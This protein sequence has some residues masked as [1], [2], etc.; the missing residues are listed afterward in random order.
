[1]NEPINKMSIT[2]S[3]SF[4][5]AITFMQ[6]AVTM[7][8]KH[9][10]ICPGSRSAPLSYAAIMLAKQEK[11]K[12]YP[13]VDERTAG[14]IAIGLSR[15]GEYKSSGTRE[16]NLGVDKIRLSQPAQ[17][18]LV[19]TTSGSAPAHLFPAILEAQAAGLPLVLVSA[20]RPGYLQQVGASQ[21]T[22]QK[23][24]FGRACVDSFSI[25]ALDA[26]Q[27]YDSNKFSSN[28]NTDSK[29]RQQLSYT[30]QIALRAL[31]CALG[32]GG[33]KPGPV[34]V[35]F[36]FSDPLVPVLNFAPENLEN[37]IHN[38]GQENRNSPGCADESYA[39]ISAES[40]LSVAEEEDEEKEK[41]EQN[42]F[43]RS[44][45]E[46]AEDELAEDLVSVIAQDEA[47][48]QI[49]NPRPELFIT[50]ILNSNGTRRDINLST[51]FGWQMS[52]SLDSAAQEQ[53]E[54][55][56][57]EKP[58]V[59]M[60]GSRAACYEPELAE[61]AKR[62]KWPLLAEPGSGA[63]TAEA[64]CAYTLEIDGPL[65]LAQR[66]VVVG[67]PTITRA[68]QKFLAKED[69][70][71]VVVC[72]HYE[73]ADAGGVANRVL[74]KLIV[75]GT[76]TQA[77]EAWYNEVQNYDQ[78]IRAQIESE[79]RQDTDIENSI[80]AF[81]REFCKYVGKNNIPSYL[82]ASS[83]VRDADLLA[84]HLCAVQTNRGLAG[85]DGTLA[86]A[87]GISYGVNSRVAV[88][89]G[90]IAFAYDFNSLIG[91]V[92]N[93]AQ[94]DV[95]LLDDGGGSIFSSLEHR[96]VLNPENFRAVFGFANFDVE[97]ATKAVGGSYFRVSKRQEIAKLLD[98]KPRTWL[99]VFHV[100]QTLQAT[101]QSRVSLISGIRRHK[102]NKRKL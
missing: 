47:L 86:V 52:G 81:T 88:A 1:M 60:A 87:R 33:S 26:G 98:E 93:A 37:R 31:V 36:E 67:A 101:S 5:S 21:T 23:D 102:A 80:P 82:A 91:G 20:D 29:Y 72:S 32:Y 43:A 74:P 16:K 51:S 57:C 89:L 44:A 50:G 13:V 75:K 45:G 58:T 2:Y 90:D 22:R 12:I 62:S 99:R 9:V 46:L 97:Q 19:I 69:R 25:P 14:F 68:Q 94:I 64:L 73:W 34:Q 70:E 38:Y 77:T 41:H 84:E 96:G 40:I 3:A 78:E 6:Q 59:I 30:Q 11:A 76:P 71:V 39:Q 65:D 8:V 100:K 55:L 18:V 79:F 49:C 28:K 35:N 61:I 17:P 4:L 85:I 27:F 54:I 56:S 83:V 10:V 95:L 48:S 92:G 53:F 63:R 42:T 7:G 66:V 24:M 15:A